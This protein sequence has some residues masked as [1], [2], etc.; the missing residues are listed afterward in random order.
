MAVTNYSAGRFPAGRRFLRSDLLTPV[1]WGST[2]YD[3]VPVD[4][5]EK[6]TRQKAA[7]SFKGE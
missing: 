3:D 2:L 7:F 4:K 5:N 1:G 6:A